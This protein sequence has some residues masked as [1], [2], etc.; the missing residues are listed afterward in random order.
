[1]GLLFYFPLY[2]PVNKFSVM[3]GRGIANP[4]AKIF[5][6]STQ[7]PTLGHDPGDIMKV[8]FDT[9]VRTHK[10]WYKK[11]CNSDL[12]IF[13]LLIPPQGYEFDPRVKILLALCS[14]NHPCQF[15]M[16][17][18]HVRKKKFGPLGTTKSHPWGMTQTTEQKSRPL[19]FIIY[20]MCENTRK[21][22]E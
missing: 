20:F 11:L 18:D 2:V 21:S 19:C 9:F 12:I 1:M 10:V 22:L 5:D 17:H 3:S 14:T 8:P 4:D 16:P 7:S 15:D 6:P 13:D